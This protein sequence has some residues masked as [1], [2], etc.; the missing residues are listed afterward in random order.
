[1]GFSIRL[2]GC[3]MI[4]EIWGVVDQQASDTFLKELLECIAIAPRRVILDLS[5]V[6]L[7]SEVNAYYLIVT[8]RM[9]AALITD[10]R[11]RGGQGPVATQ[12]RNLS[13]NLSCDPAFREVPAILAADSDQ[14]DLTLAANRP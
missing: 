1:M 2:S 14:A 13:E 9:L 10:V 3:T 12:L 4:V 5:R 7:L 6:M 8:C 11:V